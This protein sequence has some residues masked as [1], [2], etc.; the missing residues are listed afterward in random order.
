MIL[1]KKKVNVKIKDRCNYTQYKEGM[2]S[3]S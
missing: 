1:H 2:K 3:D